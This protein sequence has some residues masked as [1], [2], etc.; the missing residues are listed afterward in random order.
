MAYGLNF[1]DDLKPDIGKE[2]ISKNFQVENLGDKSHILVNS[3]I[4]SDGLT[5]SEKSGSAEL[6]YKLFQAAASY[7][8]K[9][10]DHWINSKKT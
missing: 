10:K 8:Q 6:E 5:E 4:S 7:A 2:T 1:K 9:N 3:E